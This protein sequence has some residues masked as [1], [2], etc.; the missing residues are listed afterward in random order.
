M[1]S[2]V[3]SGSFD[4]ITLGHLDIIER[5]SKVFDKVYAVILENP[6]KKP[7]FALKERLDM[8]KLAVGSN[9]I[10]DYYN[11]YTVDYCAKVGADYIVRGIRDSGSVDYELEIDRINKTINNNIQT[12][13]FVADERYKN[14]SSTMVREQL[15]KSESIS[16]LVPQRIID[17][18]GGYYGECK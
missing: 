18:I 11:G 1:A 7:L 5:A 6:T 17:I 3:V 2:C 14:I 15:A 8:I 4:P 12:I 10:S 16:H 13:F 9:V